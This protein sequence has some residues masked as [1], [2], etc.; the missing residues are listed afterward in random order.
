MT[1]ISLIAFD[2]DDTLWGS[3]TYFNTVEKVYCENSCP[4]MLLQ[5]R[6]PILSAPLKRLI[7]PLLGYGSKA[8]ML[9]LI[10][11]AVK[12]SHGKV[13]GYDIGQMSR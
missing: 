12:I 5:M 13:K 2:A 7:I 6:C 8:F 4:R 9:S 1:E 11:N 10:E 3:Q